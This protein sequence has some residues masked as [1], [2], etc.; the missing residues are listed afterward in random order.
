MIKQPKDINF[1]LAKRPSFRGFDNV[2]SFSYMNEILQCLANIK[3]ITDYLLKVNKY[4]EI[5]DNV[6]L[7]PLT[8]QYCQILIGLFCNISNTGS[9]SP[10]VFKVFIEEMI[11]SF[12]GV[13]ANDS[14]DLNYFSFRNIKC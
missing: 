9:Y 6:A 8:L 2:G 7:C 5:Y 12:Q 13:Q 14:K 1:E 11:P 10:K 3:P 4:G